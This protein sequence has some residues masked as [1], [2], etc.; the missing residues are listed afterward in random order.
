MT[1]RVFHAKDGKGRFGFEATTFPDDFR[2]VAEV[3]ASKIGEVFQLTN[4]IDQHWSE[5]AGVSIP[6]N[7][8]PRTV[9]STSVGDVIQDRNRFFAIAPT[10]FVQLATLDEWF[11]SPVPALYGRQS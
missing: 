2:L 5:N 7:V 3:K 1:F 4:H 10:G 6:G 8:D 11:Q 9:R